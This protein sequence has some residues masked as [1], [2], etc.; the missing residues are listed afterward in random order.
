MPIANSSTLNL[1]FS[2]IA[3]ITG[4]DAFQ[5]RWQ[6]VLQNTRK[7]MNAKTSEFVIFCHETKNLILEMVPRYMSEN[8][9]D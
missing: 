2:R 1:M 3:R 8:N 6:A 4:E 9:L 5:D 7:L